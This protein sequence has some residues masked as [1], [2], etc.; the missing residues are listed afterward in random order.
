MQK[1][2]KIA[3]W[4]CGYIGLSTMMYY[5]KK[6]VKSIGVDI[7]SRKVELIN[8]G[9]CPVERLEKWL[10]FELKPYIDAE[11]I[12]VTTD[13][14]EALDVDIHF[15]AVN[16]EKNEKPCYDAIE[17][18]VSKIPED[19]LVIIESTLAP[20]IAD[21]IILKKLKRVCIAPRRDWFTIEWEKK[22]PYMPRV[23]GATD[24]KTADEAEEILSIVCKNLIR[25]PNYRY[26]EMVKSV[27]NMLRHIHIAVAK[28]LSIAYPNFDINK[29]LELASTKWNIERYYVAIRTGGYCISLAT[30]CILEGTKYPESLS[31]LKEAKEQESTTVIHTVTSLLNRIKKIEEKKVAVLSLCYLGDIAVDI[32]SPT[33]YL[34]PILQRNNVRVGVN[35]IYFSEEYIKCKFDNI[36]FIKFPDGLK[37]YNAIIVVANHKVY[38]IP[39]DTLIKYLNKCK[40]ILDN[41]G[42]WEKYREKFKKHGID[43]HRIGD[44]GW[45]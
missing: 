29:V 22:L 18:V 44:A 10:G 7:D 17:D 40:V 6:E 34:V 3:V 27:E 5:A 25:A 19:K 42:I 30:N 2:D 43:Y 23:Y 39:F 20:N 45:L 15:I 36:D 37:D 41:H 14:R 4:G 11:Y 26:A 21:E 8:K 33:V 1:V 9:I 31:I 13:Y 24:N 32:G 38:D 16:T 12:K 35:D 28:Q